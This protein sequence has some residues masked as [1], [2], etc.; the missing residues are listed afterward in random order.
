MQGS[1]RINGFTFYDNLV[2]VSTDFGIVAID[3]IKEEIKDTYY[4]GDLGESIRVNGTSILNSTIYAATEKGLLSANVNDPLLIQYQRWKRENG[5][6]N[7][8]AECKDLTVFGSWIIAVEGNPDDQKDIVWAYNGINWISI[9]NQYF[10][11]SSVRAGSTRLMVTSKEGILTYT[12]VNL[13]PTSMA[14]YNFTWQ[15]EPEMALP[16]ESNK[17]AIADHGFWNCLRRIRFVKFNTTQ[18]TNK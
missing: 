6:S 14:G 18:R 5:F 8:N 11:I 1:K 12:S 2:F 15:F 16:V 13:T 3:L 17:V 9:G 10:T 4:I 7:I